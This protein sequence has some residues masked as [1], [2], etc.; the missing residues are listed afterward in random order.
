MKE[1]SILK[2]N[3]TL[4]T[5]LEHLKFLYKGIDILYKISDPSQTSEGIDFYITKINNTN[6]VNVKSYYKNKLIYLFKSAECFVNDLNPDDER[7]LNISKIDL[8]DLI[9]SKK[10]EFLKFN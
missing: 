6:P 10:I 7:Y 9:T 2:F 3:H 4:Y 1:E 8:Q 5:N